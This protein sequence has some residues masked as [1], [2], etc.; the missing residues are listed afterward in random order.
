MNCPVG[1]GGQS[2]LYVMTQSNSASKASEVTVSTR[3]VLM[4]PLR[5]V[6]QSKQVD[7]DVPN[8]GQVVRDE[9]SESVN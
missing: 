8:D 6:I 5:E 3:L 2:H 4:L 9:S 7:H 1:L